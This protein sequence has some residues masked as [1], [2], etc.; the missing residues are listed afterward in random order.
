MYVAHLI[1]FIHREAERVLAGP[2]CL[3]DCV[4]RAH[5]A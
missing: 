1:D 2:L 3:V 4:Y 5:L